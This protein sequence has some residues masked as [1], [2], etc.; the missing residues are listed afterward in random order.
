M[1]VS[2]SGSKSKTTKVGPDDKVVASVPAR[3][4][5][6]SKTSNNY[7]KTPEFGPDVQLLVAEFIKSYTCMGQHARRTVFY[8]AICGLKLMQI[9]EIVRHGNWKAV[10]TSR[11][12][13]KYQIEF[14]SAQRYIKTAKLAL[15]A[16]WDVTDEKSAINTFPENIARINIGMSA[17]RTS[18]HDRAN[19]WETSPEVLLAV[20][21]TMGSIDFDPTATELQ[22]KE[23][24]H[25]SLTKNND[26]LV[27]SAKWP[28][29]VFVA[30]GLKANFPA[31]LKKAQAQIELGIASQVIIL[32]P[33]KFDSKLLPLISRYPVCLLSNRMEVSYLVDDVNQIAKLDAD[34]ALVYVSEVPNLIR[35]IE[36]FFTIG[37][38]FLPAEHLLS[39]I[40]DGQFRKNDTVALLNAPETKTP[41]T[42]N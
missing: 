23:H 30:P 14:R 7:S 25:N 6:V 39:Q 4:I 20:K 27:A 38:V 8:A 3:R 12:R 41:N 42:K 9:K 31:W 22:A 40:V 37:K 16:G 13:T 11:I 5:K 35:F 17:S 18:Q 33:A 10:F 32:L 36:A 34:M 21:K 1:S 28:G 29:N 2:P 24:P 15:D 26:G 19:E